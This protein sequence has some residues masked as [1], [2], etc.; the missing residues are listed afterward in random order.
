[1]ETT[2]V[3]KNKRIDLSTLDARGKMPPQCIEIE[4][5]VLGACMLE[6]TSFDRA[7]TLKPEHF[8]IDAHQCI[9]QAFRTLSSKSQ[10][11]DILTVT[12]QLKTDGVLEIVGGPYMITKLTSRVSSA[13]NI[14]YHCALIYQK[15]GM[16]ELI[17]IGGEMLREGY[18]DETD[19]FELHRVM[20]SQM[21][22]ILVSD[23]REMVD[24]LTAVRK[25]TDEI[26]EIQKKGVT[27]TGIDTGWSK[28]N[29]ITHGWQNGHLII[30]AAR[31]GMGK[32]AK[33]IN[34]VVNIV[35][36]NIPAA[37]FS[38]EMNL[39]QL[40]DRILSAETGIGGEYF[41]KA[42][43]TSNEWNII[44]NTKFSYPLY[45][46]DSPNGSLVVLKS[47]IRKAV[48]KWGIKIAVVDY[49]QLMQAKEKGDSRQQ[50]IGKISRGLKLLAKELNIPIIALAQLSREAEG[51][52][53]Q[54]NHLREG[55]DIEQDADLVIFLYDPKAHEK[56]NESPVI[57]EI[58]AKNR[59][60]ATGIKLMQFKKATQKFIEYNEPFN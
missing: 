43:L 32:S 17:R 52:Q 31:P 22:K 28:I 24:L 7:Y 29:Q 9:F 57:E 14:E 33:A 10:P 37:I 5:A 6:K 41:K 46:D 44:S 11:I 45:I 54:L 12:E 35:K 19:M 25:R 47:K 53:P 2:E 26:A 30:L 42:D 13:A 21:D 50:E 20:C 39:A 18:E 4:E 1:M 23:D 48:K 27:T 59:E 51:V 49:L 60:G 38:L 8:Y 15:W 34:L 55:G 40:V 58:F 56:D 16:R 36:Q 3:R